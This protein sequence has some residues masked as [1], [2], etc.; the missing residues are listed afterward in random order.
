MEGLVSVSDFVSYL[1]QRGLAVL[2]ADVDS[3]MD[4]T[5]RA[6][7]RYRWLSVAQ[8]E[9]AKLWGNVGRSAIHEIIR[10]ECAPNAVL[11]EDKKIK[12]PIKVHQEEVIRV[13][14]KRQELWPVEL[15]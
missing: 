14:K 9:A 6:V 4:R 3:R 11:K 8:I 2:P 7:L 1:E 12:S 15:L 5:R 10:R 13:A